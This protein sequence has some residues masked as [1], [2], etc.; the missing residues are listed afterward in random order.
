MAE[1]APSFGLLKKKGKKP[2]VK[3]KSEKKKTLVVFNK[4]I[5][6]TNKANQIERLWVLIQKRKAQYK[7]SMQAW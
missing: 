2:L 3:V 1:T 6:K 5:S 4:T 7:R